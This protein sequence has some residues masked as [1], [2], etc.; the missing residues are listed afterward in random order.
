MSFFERK[1]L[2]KHMPDY[3][4]LVLTG[5]VVTNKQKL[6]QNLPTNQ[7]V[8]LIAYGLDNGKVAVRFPKEACIHLHPNQSR[9]SVLFGNGALFLGCKT[10]R[11]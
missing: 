3:G 10:A 1:M 11:A 6:A 4:P 5:S 8:Q 7:L 9:S 2:H